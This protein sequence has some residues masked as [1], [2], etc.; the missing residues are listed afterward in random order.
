M[1]YN[2]IKTIYPMFNDIQ[3]RNECDATR[4]GARFLNV[5]SFR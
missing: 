5:S 2:E 3:S 1:Q 4:P